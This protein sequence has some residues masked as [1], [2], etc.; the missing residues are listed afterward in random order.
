MSRPQF[1]ISL[2]VSIQTVFSVLCALLA[3][4]IT[5]YNYSQS[6]DSALIIADQFME[7]VNGTVL[8]ELRLM[9]KPV[10]TL[11]ETLPLSPGVGQKP[12]GAEHPL[13]ESFI[14]ALDDNESIYGIYLGWDDGDFYQIIKLRDKEPLRLALGAPPGT[15]YALRT[16]RRASDGSAQQTWNFLDAD[17]SPLGQREEPT[18][19]DP[20]KR[21]WYKLALGRDRLIKTK[22]YVFSSTKSLG[23]T[24]AHDFEG[25]TPGVL[26][27]DITLHSLGSI[28]G[29]R[30]LGEGGQIFLFSADGQITGHQDPTKVMREIVDRQGII[31]TLPT[32]VSDLDN[33]VV[34]A[35]YE[36]YANGRDLER[37]VFSTRVGDRT[38]LARLTPIDKGFGS[39]EYVA[40]T[41]PED[42]FTTPLNAA[43][44]QSLFFALALSLLVY[45]LVVVASRRLA[46]PL[47]KMTAEAQRIQN[48]ELDDPITMRSFIREIDNLSLAMA[49][50]KTV[51]RTFGQFVPKDLVRRFIQ[52][53]LVPERG[54]DR[55]N[56]TFLFTDIEDFT[57]ISDDLSPEDVMLMLS[58]YFQKLVDVMAR[59]NGTVDKF[60]GDG[61]MAF[62]NAP[63]R[64]EAHTVQACLA[65]LHGARALRDFCGNV[66]NGECLTLTTRFGLH[67]GE[68]VVGN[69]GSAERMNYT[70][71]GATVNI[72]SRIEG[73]NKYYGTGILASQ[74]V[75]DATGDVFVF[76]IVD[77]VLPKGALH[78]LVIHEL[79]GTRPGGPY[80]DFAVDQQTLA[81]IARWEQA[82]ELYHQ[83]RWAAAHEA[84][85]ALA[86]KV[87]SR[88]ESIYIE[89]TRRFLD[90]PPPDD[91]SGV[92]EYTTK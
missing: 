48:F 59:Y 78:P 7:E 41:A 17:K 53:D 14:A 30:H 54:G 45:P 6:T 34:K 91:W 87:P 74:H 31:R 32:R 26:G 46:G 51:L 90:N 70:A 86:G 33:P 39:R 11:G 84:F 20:R 35:V 8:R 40:V 85:T 43:R 66:G 73:L 67:V 22:L 15:M 79:L 61:I 19:Y 81:R 9:F 5:W 44:R 49:R 77:A 25:P 56:L 69:V 37:G 27:I 13:Q 89:R 68:A 92:E 18:D 72:A 82:Y 47:N 65:A 1:R 28:L 63:V 21:P 60:I 16:L 36:E 4:S 83:R 50:M 76:R 3:V 62:W 52:S 58:E 88:L 10:Q 75:A 64:T 24:V 55:R 38:I 42:F 2:S 57:T 71:L 23:T 29:R 80:P 12:D